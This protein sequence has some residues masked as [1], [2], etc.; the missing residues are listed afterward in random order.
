MA[1]TDYYVDLSA[2]HAT[3]P[4]SAGGS[5]AACSVAAGGSLTPGVAPGWD[6]TGNTLAGRTLTIGAGTYT[7]ATHNATAILT[8]SGGDPAENATA[9][10]WRIGAGTTSDPYLSLGGA[11]AALEATMTAPRRVFVRGNQTL[12][13]ALTLDRVA[14]TAYPLHWIGCT[15]TGTTWTR[16]GNV[17]TTK[18]VVSCSTYNVVLSGNYQNV[19]GITFTGS[20]T[21]YQVNV[22]GTYVTLVRCRC[23]AAGSNANA[24][25]LRLDGAG[26]RA[27]LCFIQ[28]PD[29][30]ND[31]AVSMGGTANAVIGCVVKGGDIACILGNS[32]GG[33]ALYNIIYGGTTTTNGIKHGSTGIGWYVGNTIFGVQEDGIEVTAGFPVVMGNLIHGGSG[34]VT[35]NPINFSGT[36]T[37]NLLVAFNAWY[38]TANN[39]IAGMI[40]TQNPHAGAAADY[41]NMVFNYGLL[42][43]D[44]LPNASTLNNAN[45]FDL[46]AAYRALADPGTYEAGD[47]AYV[48]YRD[49]GAVQHADPAG[50]G[51]IWMPR[52]RQV[53]V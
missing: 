37:N 26:S 12:S 18:P 7:I 41:G 36:A 1:W 39:T 25:A 31:Y 20:S 50:G 42:G 38:N 52:A 15:G 16:I 30:T 3:T 27:I 46:A 29:T 35:D 24:W 2:S 4:V 43:G 14:T 33:G 17:A 23:I 32:T 19:E 5:G 28:A 22:T 13:A 45:D 40:E 21:T 47:Y 34:S 53:G 48:S 8:W 9:G 44:P 6:A 10:A 49:H 51:G 11:N